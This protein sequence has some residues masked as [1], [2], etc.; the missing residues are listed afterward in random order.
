MRWSRIQVLKLISTKKSVQIA[1]AEEIKLSCGGSYIRIDSGG[2]EHGTAK[3]W[4]VHASDY[5]MLGPKADP[6]VL[7]NFNA[8]HE[9]WMGLAVFGDNLQPLE[10]V[11]IAYTA[12]FLD[13]TVRQGTLDANGVAMLEKVPPGFA[14]V[15]YTFPPPI[16]KSRESMDTLLPLFYEMQGTL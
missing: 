1:A 10:G 7:P 13:G 9:N 11:P 16:E 15:V 5:D 3:N 14:S 8:P 4:V 2:I 12:T 6:V